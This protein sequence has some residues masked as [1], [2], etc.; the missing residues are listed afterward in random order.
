MTRPG[1]VPESAAVWE[2]GPQLQ[3][4]V[5]GQHLQIAAAFT[6]ELDQ[7]QRIEC[8]QGMIGHHH[9]RAAAG[10]PVAFDVVDLKATIEKAQTLFDKGEGRQVCVGANEI[11]RGIEPRRTSQ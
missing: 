11:G 1:P 9:Q 4:P 3:Q 8:A 2:P 6:D 10:Q 5:V 7:R